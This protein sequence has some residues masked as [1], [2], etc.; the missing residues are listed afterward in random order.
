[1]GDAINIRSNDN[2]K[3]LGGSS[4]IGDFVRNIDAEGNLSI[5]PDIVDQL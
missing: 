1:M 2:S 5:D 4:P 3:S